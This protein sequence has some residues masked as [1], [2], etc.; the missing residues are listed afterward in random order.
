MKLRLP[1]WWPL[2]ILVLAAW[3]FT[4]WLGQRQDQPLAEALRAT[5]RPGDILMLSSTT[6]SYCTKARSWLTE[7]RVPHSECFIERDPACLA[8]FQAR[9]APGTPTFVVRGQTVVGFDRKRMASLLSRP[10]AAPG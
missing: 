4:Q 2:P 9:S 5:A 7:Q 10:A 1:S 6:C 8:E 3:G